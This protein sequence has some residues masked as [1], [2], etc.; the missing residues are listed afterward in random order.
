M[1]SSVFCFNSAEEGVCSINQQHDGQISLQSGGIVILSFS[2]QT[3]AA[4][5]HVKVHVM[6]T[7]SVPQH[8]FSCDL[9]GKELR[10]VADCVERLN[11]LN[12]MGR[13]WGQNM[14]LQ[15]C[16]ANMLLTDIETKVNNIRPAWVMSYSMCVDTGFK[17]HWVCL[18]ECISLCNSRNVESVCWG[19]VL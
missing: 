11:L 16:G 13:V 14:L 15:V 5:S 2:T 1:Q 18:S 12:E 9:D 7:A 10:S 8:L 6:F 4:R 17:G 3:R 19:P